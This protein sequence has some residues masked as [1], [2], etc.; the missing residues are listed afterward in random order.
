MFII[1]IFV[2]LIFL[3]QGDKVVIYFSLSQVIRSCMIEEV[4]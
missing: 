4:D 3:L 1:V 2:Y